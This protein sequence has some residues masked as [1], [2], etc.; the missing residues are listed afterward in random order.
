MYPFLSRSASLTASSL[1][2]LILADAIAVVL[3]GLDNRTSTLELLSI[4]HFS[5]RTATCR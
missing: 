3:A 2:V 5:S 4:F 1:S